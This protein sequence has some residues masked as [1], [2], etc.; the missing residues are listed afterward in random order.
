[1]HWISFLALWCHVTD[2]TVRPN[3][4]TIFKLVTTMGVCYGFL[5]LIL[6]MQLPACCLLQKLPDLPCAE[7][8]VSSPPKKFWDWRCQ[9]FSLCSLSPFSFSMHFSCLN[10]AFQILCVLLLFTSLVSSLLLA[11]LFSFVESNGG[12]FSFSPFTEGKQFH[13]KLLWNIRII[14]IL[15]PKLVSRGCLL[16]PSHPDWK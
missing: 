16:I 2:V 10:S 13:D 8:L 9:L 14:N 5:H 11:R 4:S 7:D 6:Q 15:K 12:S 3:H 1:M